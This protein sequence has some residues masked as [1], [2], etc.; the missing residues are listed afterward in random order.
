MFW[1]K[2]YSNS[3]DDPFIQE[4]LSIFGAN[5]YLAWFGLIEIIAKENKNNIT[6]QLE[7]S[8]V[9]LKQK[10]HISPGKL[11]EIFT[12][13]SG[14][15]KL[16]FRK[17][18]GKVQEKSNKTLENF[19]FEFPKIAE[20]KDNYTK[21]L[22]GSCKNT[23]KQIE[24]EVEVDKEEEK[25]IKIKKEPK[26][27]IVDLHE[28]IINDLNLVLGTKYRH[29]TKDI[30]KLLM[31]RLADKYTLDDFKTVHRNMFQAW[32]RDPKMGEFLRPHTLYTE[33]FQSYLNKRPPTL[34]QQG[35]VSEKTEKNI[36]VVNRW[37]A[38]EEAKDKEDGNAE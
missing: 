32:N 19:Y 6:G 17:S 38:S 4:L 22:Q 9:F 5:G 31:A 36:E 24:V 3:L 7:V 18:P 15:G 26:E 34:S 33:K 23:S 10:F 37:L 14:K 8:P 35:I 13:C 1:F 27:H 12:F 28:E 30:Q 11:E 29:T 20:I 21:D 25:K 2:H 16:L